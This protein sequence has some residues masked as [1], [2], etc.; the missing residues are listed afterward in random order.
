MYFPNYRF[1][2]TLGDRSLT[3]RTCR[4]RL[5]GVPTLPDDAGCGI[6]ANGERTQS[7]R[8]VYTRR[9]NALHR[10]A[11][12]Q[13]CQFLRSRVSA[14]PRVIQSFTQGTAGRPDLWPASCAPMQCKTHQ[15]YIDKGSRPPAYTAKRM[16][17]STTVEQGQSIVRPTKRSCDCRKGEGV[18]ISPACLGFQYDWYPD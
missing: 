2:C 15:D 17:R 7:T 11:S 16:A 1:V 3:D 5:S 14:V 18:G 10:A 4:V 12:D 8:T 6:A 9:G 13:S